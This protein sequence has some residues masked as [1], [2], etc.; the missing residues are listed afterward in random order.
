M[1]VLKDLL[2]GS[3]SGATKADGPATDVAAYHAFLLSITLER[4]GVS[5]DVR[6][7]IH[8]AIDAHLREERCHHITKEAFEQILTEAGVDPVACEQAFAELVDDTG[9][10]VPF[11]TILVF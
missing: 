7:G 11:G 10:A 2:P 4:A 9:R 3:W 8:E 5:Q 6:K 1:A